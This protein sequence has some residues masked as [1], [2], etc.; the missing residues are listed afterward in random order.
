MVPKKDIKNNNSEFLDLFSETSIH[1]KFKIFVLITLKY[2]YFEN[3]F[4][5]IN[6]DNIIR[7]YVFGIWAI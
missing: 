1:I 2:Y 5:G 4:F 7:D 6:D 3:F